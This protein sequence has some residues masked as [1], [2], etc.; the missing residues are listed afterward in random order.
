MTNV[1]HV[2]LHLSDGDDRACVW[3]TAGVKVMRVRLGPGGALPTHATSAD[4]LI[5]PLAGRLKVATAPLTQEI[6]PGE[7]M[8]LPLD[9]EM[10]VSNAAEGT[11][12][13]LVVRS[14]PRSG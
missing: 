6:G 5:V 14:L 10:T 2:D 7:A 11:T 3:E 4:V 8:N 13:F 1:Q 12:T 9:M